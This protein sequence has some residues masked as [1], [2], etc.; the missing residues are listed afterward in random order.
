MFQQEFLITYFTQ[1]LDA[2]YKQFN[3]NK[4]AIDQKHL[5]L[6]Q[7]HDLQ[8]ILVEY[9]KLF[10]GSLCVYPYEKVHIDILIGLEL[11]HHQEY[12]VHCG[13]E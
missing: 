9:G 8:Q 2:K 7:C 3:T 5:N 13:N 6:N 4:V 1:M 10:D 11:V 12:S